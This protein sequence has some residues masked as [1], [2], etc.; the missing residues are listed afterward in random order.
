MIY[1][2]LLNIGAAYGLYA[3]SRYVVVGGAKCIEMAKNY[4]SSY[5]IRKGRIMLSRA[6]RCIG[7]S[8]AV[9]FTEQ[10]KIQFANLF[11]EMH[12][13]IH[14]SCRK[15]IDEGISI[16]AV[17]WH[18]IAGSKYFDECISKSDIVIYE[19]KRGEFRILSVFGTIVSYDEKWQTYVSGEHFDHS[20]LYE[21]IGGEK[22]GHTGL[23]FPST[24]SGS[25]YVTLTEMSDTNKRYRDREYENN[26]SMCNSFISVF[27]LKTVS[28]LYEELKNHGRLCS[29]PD[30]D[31][32]IKTHLV[33]SEP[34]G[35][36]ELYEHQGISNQYVPYVPKEINCYPRE[37]YS[38]N[39]DHEKITY[40]GLPTPVSCKNGRHCSKGKMN[41]KHP[42]STEEGC[43]REVSP[44]T[45]DTSSTSDTTFTGVADDVVLVE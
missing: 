30:I 11:Y 24:Q 5:N 36:I 37:R 6:R 22:N 40:R 19:K 17:K 42:R 14:S 45:G 33:V 13:E 8:R 38:P 16:L 10:E 29:K 1:D 18:M 2:L 21:F 3:L 41:G 43:H 7:Q 27:L 20:A 44:S 26:I 35:T 32:F 12:P 34:S 28:A 15:N 9:D 39:P 23:M 4:Y 25:R 31:R